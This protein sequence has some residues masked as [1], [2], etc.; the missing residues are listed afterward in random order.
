MNTLVDVYQISVITTFIWYPNSLG[1]NWIF[2][3][4]FHSNNCNLCTYQ[5]S[6]TKY[7]CILLLSKYQRYLYATFLLQMSESKSVI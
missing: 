6:Y 2:G 1:P 7:I 5:L 4:E 3:I